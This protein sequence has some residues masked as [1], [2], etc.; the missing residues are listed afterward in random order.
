MHVFPYSI[1]PG[2]PAADMPGQIEKA[3]KQERAVRA[4]QAARTMAEAFADGQLGQ[5]LQVL[6][7]TEKD[8]LWHGHSENYLEVAAPGEGLHG[9]V[10]TVEITG[11]KGTQLLGQLV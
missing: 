4:S 11:R 9:R 7:E 6:F 1:R 8:G 3:V 5:T 2:T 10:L